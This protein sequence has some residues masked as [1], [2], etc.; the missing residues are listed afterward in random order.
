MS[1]L[2]MASAH[3]HEGT[4]EGRSSFFHP[5][6]YGTHMTLFLPGFWGEREWLKDKG[7]ISYRF[8]VGEEMAWNPSIPMAWLLL[9]VLLPSS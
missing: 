7:G 8:I 1:L 5:E 6:Q 4:E 9:W 3:P 2:A